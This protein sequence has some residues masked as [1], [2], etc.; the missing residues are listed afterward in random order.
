M[1]MRSA[2]MLQAK[3]QNPESKPY[4]TCF[5]W[6]VILAASFSICILPI[7][8][9]VAAADQKENATDPR[10]RTQSL[11]GRV[12]WFSEAMERLHK[13]KAVPEAKERTLALETHDGKLW[14]IVEDLRG[15]SFRTDARLR[16]MTVELFVRKYRGSDAIQILKVF[17]VKDG[18]RFVVDYWCDVCA[19]IMFESGTC[20]CCQDDNRLRKRLTEHEVRDS[21]AG[22]AKE[23]DAQAS[24]A[25]K[26]R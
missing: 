23:I 18:K 14:T 11:R 25:N 12:V 6:A 17:E 22:E 19:I 21:L 3:S 10:F 15:R 7:H 24:P 20:D 8:L 16:E 2:T 26:R 9:H 4:L 1:A 13:V 5:R